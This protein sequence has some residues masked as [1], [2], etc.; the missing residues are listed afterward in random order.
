[1]AKPR[2]FVSS[3][4][5]DLKHIRRNIELFIE[6]MGYEPVLFES[7][8]IPF[9]DKA[10]LDMS[11]YREI[12][13]CHIQI[14]IIGG[15]YGAAS[16]DEKKEINGLEKE[17]K[18]YEFYNSITRKE[19]LKARGM[20][21]PVFFFVQKGVLAEYETYK[22][23]RE[24]IS[25]N[26]AHVDSINIFKLIDD[27]FHEKAGNYVKEFENFDDIQIWLRDQWAGLFTNYL[28]KEKSEYQ[29]KNLSS[30]VNELSI[31]VN[32]LK[33]YS[34]AIMKTIKPDNYEIIIKEEEKKMQMLV[35]LNELKENPYIMHLTSVHNLKVD[36]IY[37][38]LMSCETY[39]D[40]KDRLFADNGR[41]ISCMNGNEGKIGMNAA[42]KILNKPAYEVVIDKEDNEYIFKE[43]LKR[44]LN[45]AMKYRKSSNKKLGY[46]D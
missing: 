3:T 37:E 11:C 4:Y 42:R 14:L 28:S 15:R 35:K 29:I 23:N 22:R 25:I 19:F 30:Q 46:L 18:F 12:E 39:D 16:S 1:M 26:Y 20:G 36:V 32:S 44:P 13:N 43:N 34:Q 27:I 6:Q 38:A 5:F 10:P 24:N 31:I 41:P 40:L 7:G 17:E 8:D 2:I 33:E 9:E 45:R 21:I